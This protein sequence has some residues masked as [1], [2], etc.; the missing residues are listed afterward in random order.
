[1]PTEL[2]LERRRWPP[3]RAGAKKRP[4]KTATPGQCGHSP[5]A[6]Q[7]DSEPAGTGAAP[8][9]FPAKLPSLGMGL[10]HAGSISAKRAAPA[11]LP[12]AGSR[13]HPCPG[14][15]P[16]LEQLH[17]AHAALVRAATPA[18]A[19]LPAA[20]CRHGPPLVPT[21]RLLRPPA[22]PGSVSAAEL[23]C[24]GAGELHTDSSP[25]APGAGNGY[26]FSGLQPFPFT[27]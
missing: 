11:S 27:C 22:L 5:S 20:H 18:P 4:P 6:G 13:A 9:A 15:C 17:S 3:A 19:N 7:A 14:P 23:G 21:Q 25:T 24:N 2:T 8:M 16:R 1:M 12:A 26:W 10:G